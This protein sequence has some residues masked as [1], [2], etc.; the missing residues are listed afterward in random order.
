MKL[1]SMKSK[2]FLALLL[3]MALFSCRPKV[4]YVDRPV[5]APTDPNNY[6]AAPSNDNKPYQEP[7][8]NTP[9]PVEINSSNT[10]TYTNNNQVSYDQY[11]TQES[12][13][14]YYANQQQVNYGAS[15]YQTFY[16]ELSPYGAWVN[17]QGYGYAWVPA[18]GAGFTPY[19][20]NGYWTYSQY[21]WTW[22]SNYSWG[23]A[24][25]HYGRWT[26]DPGYGWVWIPGNTWAPAWVTWGH[27]NGYYG[28]AP[29]G[30]GVNNYEG[31][32][33][34]VHYWN[35]V[36]ENRIAEHNVNTYVVNHDY[37]GGYVNTVSY[38]N[39]SGSYNNSNF[40]A[41]PRRESVEGAVGHRI[42]A[43]NVSD[44]SK[45]TPGS[46][47]ITGNTLNVYRPAISQTTATH[48]APLRV[49]AAE[50]VRSVN[51]SAVHGVL[52]PQHNPI[53]PVNRR[54]ENSTV[55]PAVK[56]SNQIREKQAEPIRPI[57]T[58]PT[59]E[60]PQGRPVEERPQSRPIEE[61]PQ[62]RPAEERPQSRPIEERQQS[63]PQPQARPIE[64]RPQARPVEERPQ[65]RPIEERPQSRPA[66]ERRPEPV[67]RNPNQNP[68]QNQNQNRQPVNAPAPRPKIQ[69]Q[70]K[71][72]GHPVERK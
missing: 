31:Y 45:P 44:V 55:S 4:I 13:Q 63:R 22:V 37:N 21:G 48:A 15:S 62:S 17:Y 60:R 20:T 18:Q 50:N 64:E 9:P 42:E 16:D 7:V 69:A 70:P 39:N 14:Q 57:Q 24:P 25:F 32:R 8:N 28:W 27:C 43:V 65:S 49:V 58:R 12:E 52:A 10:P 41:G 61:R 33:P 72:T 51:S 11:N 23:W 66:P 35:F 3:S 36:P 53:A 46:H 38:I 2:L 30:P 19:S 54:P 40:N 59:E 26:M 68:N 29:I 5:A 71:P 6:S 47:A 1:T 67:I 56:P 34:P